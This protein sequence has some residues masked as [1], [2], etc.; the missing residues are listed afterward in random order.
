M[1]GRQVL[2][3]VVIAGVA[4]WLW[5]SGKISREPAPSTAPS[6]SAASSGTDSGF[7]GE[8][9]LTAVEQANRRMQEAV[10]RIKDFLTEIS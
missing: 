8:A 2:W 9:C 3:L 4:I 1:N 5:K 10:T 6:V 7:A